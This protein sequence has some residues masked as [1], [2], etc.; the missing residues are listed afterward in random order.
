MDFHLF[1]CFLRYFEIM[2]QLDFHFREAGH[3]KR[4][5]YEDP[6]HR[7][8]GTP[9]DPSGLFWACGWVVLMGKLHRAGEGT[10]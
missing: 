7:G 9:V 5:F 10:L 6:E 8:L 3:N 1:L 2:A 4:S